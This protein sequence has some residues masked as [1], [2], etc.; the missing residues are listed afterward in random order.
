MTELGFSDTAKFL[1]K[2]KYTLICSGLLGELYTHC[3]GLYPPL[4]YSTP[5]DEEHWQVLL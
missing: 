4:L 1:G 2:T 5:H 3:S